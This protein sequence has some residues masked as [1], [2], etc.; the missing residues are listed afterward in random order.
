MQRNLFTLAMVP[1]VLVG[2]TAQEQAP[3]TLTP[4]ERTAGWRLL[5]D[6]KTTAG[7]RGYKTTAMPAGWQVTPD[8]ALTRESKA[9]DLVSV[10]QFGSFE[11]SFEWKISP[12]GNSGV[13][14]HVTEDLDQPWK[15]G[16]EY[17]VLDN[18]G[19]ADG[20]KAETSAASDYAVHAPVKDVTRPVGS[21]NIGRIVVRGAHVEHWLNGVKV[22]EYEIGSPDWTGRVKQS[23]FNV[24]PRFGLAGRGHIVLQDH[25]DTVSFRSLKIRTP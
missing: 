19:H 14:Y 1:L 23:K 7:W 11:L 22:V 17:Q 3:N 6:G 10:E 13:L 18:A 2:L 20:K 21:W 4:A 5:F 9:A 12:G 8:G 24:Y 16:P 25:G 15:S